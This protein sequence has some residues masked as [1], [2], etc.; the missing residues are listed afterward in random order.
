MPEDAYWTAGHMGQHSV[1]IP[2]RNVVVV[3]LGPS[4]GRTNEYMNETVGRILEAIQTN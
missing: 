4:P 1:I 2:S 3:R